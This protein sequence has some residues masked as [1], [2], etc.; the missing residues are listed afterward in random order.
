MIVERQIEGPDLLRNLDQT[1]DEIY[2]DGVVYIVTAGAIP[3]FALCP[4]RICDRVLGLVDSEYGW[5]EMV[6]PGK[7]AALTDI[8]PGYRR[9]RF[10]IKNGVCLAVGIRVGEYETI[11]ELD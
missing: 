6:D 3:A 4:E 11:K 5:P 10:I 8:A 2:Q 9:H 7:V 1:L